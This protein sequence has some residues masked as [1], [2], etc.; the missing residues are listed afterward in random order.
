[1]D[2]DPVEVVRRWRDA[3]GQCGLI[4]ANRR[5]V[6]VGLYRCDG[7]EEADRFTSSDPTLRVLLSEPEEYPVPP[8]APRR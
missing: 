5:S 6:T 7:G 3:G 2:E 4:S 1:M 8:H